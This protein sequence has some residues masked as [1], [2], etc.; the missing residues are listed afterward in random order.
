MRLKYVEELF[1]RY[2]IFSSYRDD[3]VDVGTIDN[4]SICTVTPAEA[5]RLIKDRDE[6]IDALWTVVESFA[7]EAPLKFDRVW[8]NNVVTELL[9]KRV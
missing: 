8:Y 1:P 3:R 6:L 9:N 2:L 7:D 4:Y 5:E